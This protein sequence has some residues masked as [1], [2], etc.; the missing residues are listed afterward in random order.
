M[1]VASSLALAV[2]LTGGCSLFDAAEDTAP[3]DGGEVCESGESPR[4]TQATYDPGIPG[5]GNCTYGPSE[6]LM[7][8]GLSAADYAGSFG[9]GGCLEVERSGVATIRVRA[10]DSCLSC[11]AGDLVLSAEAFQ[12]LEPNLDVGVIDVAWRWVECDVDG[13]ISIHFMDGSSDLFL[14]VQVRDHRHRI[15]SVDAQ[16][17]GADSWRGLDRLNYNYFV[18]DPGIGFGPLDFRIRDVYGHEVIE[19]GM[20]VASD[21]LRP[22]TQQ[23]PDCE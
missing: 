8:V 6:D 14:A 1:R 12:M 21:V 17:S 2:A 3:H 4:S 13:P 16:V 19:S 18:A 11:A 20:E 15:Q 9:C 22:G 5:G 10:V 23:L 7:V